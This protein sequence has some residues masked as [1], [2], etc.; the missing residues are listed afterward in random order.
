MSFAIDTNDVEA[1]LL[2]DGWH[3]CASYVGGGSCF[4]LDSYEFVESPPPYEE[5]LDHSQIGAAMWETEHTRTI[6]SGGQ[7][8]D[9]CATG[10][11]FTT[12]GGLLIAGPLTSTLAVRVR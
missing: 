9:V 7:A 12:S 4:D 3:K 2:A 1:V 5:Q 10:F 6:F 8:D 11:T